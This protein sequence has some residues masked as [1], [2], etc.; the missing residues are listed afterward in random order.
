MHFE[1]ND[2]SLKSVALFAAPQHRTVEGQLQD[3]CP[4]RL[5][6]RAVEMRLISHALWEALT[7]ALT[8]T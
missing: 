3:S 6:I 2:Y 8:L 5:L 4:K 1:N 7:E